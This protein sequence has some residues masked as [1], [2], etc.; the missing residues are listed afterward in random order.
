MQYFK[1]SNS[2]KVAVM[3]NHISMKVKPYHPHP[4]RSKENGYRECS[5]IITPPYTRLEYCKSI[6]DG[7]PCFPHETTYVDYRYKNKKGKWV[8][9]TEYPLLVKWL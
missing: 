1:S 4:Y 5:E 7:S 6:S 3:N 8:T 2:N 9:V